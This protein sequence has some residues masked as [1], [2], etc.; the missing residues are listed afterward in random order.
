MTE[1]NIISKMRGKT[2]ERGYIKNG[3]FIRHEIDAPAV[4]DEDGTQRWFKDGV[5]HRVDGPAVYHPITGKSHY[6]QNGRPHRE[7]GPA[8]I[9]GECKRWFINGDL[10][11]EDGPAI[12]S[13]GKQRFFIRGVPVTEKIVL[14]P[15]TQTIS[16]ITSEEN[17]E[18]KRVRIER[19][20]WEKFLD[21]ANAEV[22]DSNFNE[23]ERTEEFLSRFSDMTVLVGACP[24]TG[25][26]YVM[27]V[28]PSITTCEAARAYLSQKD[29][30]KCIGAT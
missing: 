20:G 6:I 8:Y 30:K 21:Q 3:A 15:E 13:H 4:I 19:F 29:P 16:E 11:R 23:I 1:K 14:A 24:S 18:V 28:D 10:H 22:V 27:E 9:D 26:I 25:R 12:D 7:D 5:P 17:L 2:Q